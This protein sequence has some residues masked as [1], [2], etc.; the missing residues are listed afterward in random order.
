[1]TGMP[2]QEED[3]AAGGA[4]RGR[5]PALGVDSLAL[6]SSVYRLDLDGCFVFVGL[7]PAPSDGG[8]WHGHGYTDCHPLML[9]GGRLVRVTV[10]KHRWVHRLT[11]RSVTSQPPDLV[12]RRRLCTLLIAV[13]LLGALTARRGLHHAGPAVLGA[14]SIRQLQRDL[15]RACELAARTQQAVRL[16]LMNRCVP[17]PVETLW[18]AGLDPPRELARRCRHPNAPLLWTALEMLR[19]GAEQLG[20]PLSSLLAEARRRWTGPKHRF[21]I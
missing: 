9:R 13:L 15:R 21:L 3:G 6:C 17:R 18:E 19:T 7:R 12:P 5:G 2:R 4:A 11:G 20:T 16:A 10:R 14:R 1:M 8:L